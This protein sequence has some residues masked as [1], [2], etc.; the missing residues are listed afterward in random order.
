MTRSKFTAVALGAVAAFIAACPAGAS[1]K[2]TGSTVD[3]WTW[4]PIGA[5]NGDSPQASAGIKSAFRYLNST[6]GIGK[7]HHRVAVKVCATQITPTSETQCAQQAANDPKAIAIVAPITI[8]A[9]QVV[10]DIAQKA[11]LAVINPAA[12]D[13]GVASTA[14]NYPMATEYLNTAGCA[15]MMSR[16][17]KT[18]DVGFA[19]TIIPAAQA[20]IAAAIS[21][22]KRA[23]LNVVGQ[24]QYPIT[25]TDVTPFVQQMADKKPKFVVLSSSPQGVGAWI[26][27][28]ARLGVSVPICVGD[29]LIPPVVLRGLGSVANRFYVASSYPDVGWKGF[30]LLAT[31]RKQAKAEADG[32]NKA[33]AL[34]P[35]NNTEDVLIGWLSGQAVAQA[36]SKVSGGLTRAKL[37]SAL[38][39]TT[40]TLG[41]GEGALL[42]PIDFSKPNRNSKF[43]RLFNTKMFLKKWDASKK[44]FVLAPNVDPVFGDRLVK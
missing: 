44:T 33:A 31:F 8:L 5:V 43:P 17:L 2:A 25:T 18:K 24:V 36:A 6:T 30:P 21:A 3:V 40:V 16:A 15:V 28:A 29:R 13:L 9:T 27:A 14:I 12:S 23:K 4:A 11:G 26:A 35:T 42:P 19:N 1:A 20:G 22:A 34:T 10:A 32:G 37:H 7:D 38:N 39:R 41:T